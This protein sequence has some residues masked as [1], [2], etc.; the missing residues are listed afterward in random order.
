MLIPLDKQK[1]ALEVLGSIIEQ[2]QVEPGCISC[3]LYRGVQ[4]ERALLLEEMWTSEKDLERHLRSDKYQKVLL[5]VEMAGEPPEIRID[6]IAQ[7]SGVE[8]IRK[9]RIQGWER[10]AD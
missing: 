9:A 7:S 10:I 3:R 6:T 8:A 1:E 5:V 4:E 2:I